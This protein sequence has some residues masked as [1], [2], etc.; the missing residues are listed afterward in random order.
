M[1]SFGAPT[2][3]LLIVGAY[4]WRMEREDQRRRRERE[5]E[6]ESLRDKP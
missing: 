6:R 2:A 5:R 1:A 4:A 3:F